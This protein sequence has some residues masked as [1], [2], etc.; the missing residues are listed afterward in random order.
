MLSFEQAI[1]IFLAKN[2]KVVFNYHL[3]QNPKGFPLPSFSL[4]KVK[5]LKALNALKANH[6]I[7]NC[8]NGLPPLY[9][10]E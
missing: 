4:K 9:F 2:V 3:T 8:R 6:C 10:V 5:A 1:S 7:E